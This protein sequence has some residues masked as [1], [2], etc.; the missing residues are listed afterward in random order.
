MS[1]SN[2]N[3]SLLIKFSKVFPNENINP[4]QL[5]QPYG[6]K[7]VLQMVAVLNLLLQKRIEKL[8]QQVKEW[9]GD[10][11]PLALKIMELIFEGYQQEIDQ[12]MELHLINDYS[13]LTLNQIAVD[14]TEIGENE[15]VEIDKSH[16]DLFK[17][18]LWLNEDFLE[19]L[20]N[21][22]NT[23]PSSVSGL[24]VATWLLTASSI[25]YYDFAYSSELISVCQI[26]KTI[27]CYQ[28]IEN[29]NK[30]LYYEYLNSKNINSL[31]EYLRKMFS[32]VQL[33]FTDVVTFNG[34]LK[35]D[36]EFLELFNH[37]NDI[38]FSEQNQ[39]NY[40][41]ILIRNKPI[42]RVDNNQYLFLNRAMIINKIYSSIYW[43][44]KG[45]LNKNLNYNI[46]EDQFRKDYTT[47]FSEGYLVYKLLNKAYGKKSY[48]QF[49]GEEMKAIM[50][51]SE[52]DYYIRNGNKVFIYE[53]KDSFIAGKVK[54][55][56]NAEC[57]ENELEQKYY[58]EGKSEKAVK[59]LITRIKFS[60][61]KKYKFDDLY[62]VK[63][64]NIYPILI[65]YDINLTVPGIKRLLVKW[66]NI[67]KGILIED[68]KKQDIT[69]FKINDVVL[70]HI[71]GLVLLS[72]YIKANK[73]YVED[74]IDNYHK[75]NQKL[76]KPNQN[77]SFKEVKAN[78]LN[79][80][81]SFQ[82]YV[83]DYLN[84]IKP[85]NRIKPNEIQLLNH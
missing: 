68:L 49:S 27:Y 9:F 52:P 32:L 45:I 47:H 72:E 19:K 1:F 28:F 18:Y 51:H 5:L 69:G 75:R 29:Y 65:V 23:L 14:F 59:Q 10:Q 84:S 66:F 22:P 50:G 63:S 82:Q 24:D 41:F 33:C 55:S 67:E 64:L 46:T 85:K 25:S 40:D 35:E 61:L 34:K 39:K 73:L 2:L 4:Q 15:K 36:E 53:V 77:K 62:N 6:R 12:G 74:L 21:V 43:D 8:P 56:F 3:M 76:L 81:L 30:D 37:L 71:D 48:K 17:A 11:N 44:I 60:L 38:E 7:L 57:I 31:E 78:I 16:L 70:L 58:K 20:E 13:N 54:Q 79:T 26:I 83:M 42:F 80:F